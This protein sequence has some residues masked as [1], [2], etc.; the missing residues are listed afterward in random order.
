MARKARWLGLLATYR[1]LSPREREAVDRH[2]EDDDQSRELA[3]LFAE[4]DALL[5]AL[6]P[7]C[8]S[9][10]LR[11]RVMAATVARGE[12]AASLRWRPVL[13]AAL[14]LVL[15]VLVAGTG[16][17]SSGSLPGDTLYP[18]KRASEQVR[19]AFT[20]HDQGRAHYMERLVEIR[21]QEVNALLGLGRAG[22]PVAF[23]GPLEHSPEGEWLV[24]GVPV[25]FVIQ[26]RWS[27]ACP[28]T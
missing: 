15:L 4:Q 13:A 19:L 1:E 14:S 3:R 5:S 22:V 24:A 12:T 26:R 2:L 25:I 6:T 11:E 16:V 8:P 20:L 18:V 27:P 23:E 9:P 7:P 28:C 10:T 17:A 21:R